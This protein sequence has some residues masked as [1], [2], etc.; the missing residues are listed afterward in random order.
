MTRP[1][2]PYDYTCFADG[3]A[4]DLEIFRFQNRLLYSRYQTNITFSNAEPK[5]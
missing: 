5:T 1:A 4:F 2:L 3:T